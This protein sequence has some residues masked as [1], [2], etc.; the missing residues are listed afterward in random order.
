MCKISVVVP[1]YKAEKYIRRCLDSLLAQTLKD[2]ELILVDDGSPDCS[3]VICDEY[4]QKDKRVRV[5]HKSNGGVSSARQAGLDVAVGEYVIHADPDDWVEADMLKELYCK[6][7][8]TNADM[9][10]CDFYQDYANGRS[11]YVS[12]KI[13][14]PIDSRTMLANLLEGKIHGACW[15]KL[16]RRAIIK[17]YDVKFIGNIN[18]CEDRQFNI[19]LLLNAT[20]IIYIPKAYYHYCVEV[21][22]NSLIKSCPNVS[23]YKSNKYFI[24][25]A[26]EK[27]SI[28]PYYRDRY[29]V[30]NMYYVAMNL[31]IS[32]ELFTNEFGE[33]VQYFNHNSSPMKRHIVYSSLH[34]FKLFWYSMGF[35]LFITMSFLSNLKK[36][37]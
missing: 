15:N 26:A 35:L 16:V 37:F 28:I 25:F 29:I 34:G 32:Q 33:Y 36:K 4:S 27:L 18:V 30:A 2:F 9:V 8:E 23:D 6:A 12:Q 20:S 21:N 7:V 31:N 5:I 11:S 19:S 17:S 13:A 24:E 1:V 14:T 10:F 3:G 22:A